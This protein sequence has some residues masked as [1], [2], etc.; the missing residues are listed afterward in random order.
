[1]SSG[2]KPISLYTVTSSPG[3]LTATTNGTFATVTGLTNGTA[4]TFTVTATNSVG[5]SSASA[6]SNSVTPYAPTTMWTWGINDRGQLGLGQGT[7]ITRSSPTQVGALT[8][9]SQIAGG[10]GHSLA[11]KA[12]NTLWSWGKNDNYGQLGLSDYISRSSPVQVGTLANWTSIA[13]GQYHTLAR[14]T[15]NT[16]WGWGR[17]NYG[18]LGLGNIITR[19]SPVQVGTLA[20]WT[21]I[22]SGNQH[23]LALKTDG[24]LWTWGGNVAGALG[25]GDTVY[26]SS[27]VQI[28]ALTTWSAVAAGDS[29]FSLA[30][31][32]D[33]TL[34]MWGQN[35]R[36]QLGSGDTI[37]RSVPVQVGTLATW[38][39]I[40][41]GGVHALATKTDN[42]LWAWGYNLNGQLGLDDATDRS[43]PVQVGTLATW[44]SV[45]GGNKH[46]LATKTDGTLWSWGQNSTYGP[47]GLGDVLHRSSPVQVGTLATWTSIAGG[48]QFTIG[49]HT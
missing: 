2:G 3:G 42:T 6:A 32:T 33:G 49:L 40:A 39:S 44:T 41:D 14:K 21:S 23:A 37:G 30:L 26:R 10:F 35:N 48:S 7:A 43:S 47:L 38:N 16:L 12:D 36:G 46:T 1:M 11:L 34:W 15:D 45:T 5:T 24:T 18:E 9:W 8:S 31:K 13:G 17:N 25:L 22:K 27:P 19:S 29:F 20:T 28:G 4:Y